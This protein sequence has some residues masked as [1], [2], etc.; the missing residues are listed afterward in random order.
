MMHIVGGSSK[1]AGFAVWLANPLAE[2][3]HKGANHSLLCHQIYLATT[4][5]HTMQASPTALAL[6]GDIPGNP[7]EVD[8]EQELA[9][10]MRMGGV[11]LRSAH[12]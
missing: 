5:K 7:K 8:K 2:R 1:R 6:L 3:H 4:P 10:L 11:G 9:A 12:R